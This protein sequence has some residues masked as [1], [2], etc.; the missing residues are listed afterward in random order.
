MINFWKLAYE[1]V[2]KQRDQYKEENKKLKT[3][4]DYAYKNWRAALSMGSSIAEEKSKA[5]ME[6]LRLK[7]EIERL[8][9]KLME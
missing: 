2:K 9:N 5:D 8:Q 6:N 4:L 3:E 1:T 7:E